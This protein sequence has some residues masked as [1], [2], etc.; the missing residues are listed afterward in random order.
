MAHLIHG[1]PSRVAQFT[2]P[3]VNERIERRTAAS[4][5]YHAENPDEIPARLREL[6][7]EW[8][9]E[10]A[11]ATMSSAVSLTGLLLA[12]R[13]GWKW[14]ALPTAV[15]GFYL[16]HS[17][18]GW[19]PP[20]ALLRKAGFR[21]VEEIDEERC[22]LW[23]LLEESGGLDEES[24][25]ERESDDTVNAGR[26]GRMSRVGSNGADMEMKPREPQPETSDGA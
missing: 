3:R 5:L 25:D 10:R 18:Q 14:L 16:Q 6:D 11:L 21:T 8:D 22:A 12:F 7:T 13:R 9:I 24:G 2:D 15:Q 17:V 4:I 1:S 19:C 26:G 20:L 23:A